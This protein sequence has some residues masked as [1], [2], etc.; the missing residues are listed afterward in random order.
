MAF[1]TEY[2]KLNVFLLMFIIIQLSYKPIILSIY[3]IVHLLNYLHNYFFAKL[4]NYTL[5]NLSKLLSQAYF[6]PFIYFV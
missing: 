1:L 3:Y 5:F 2:K 4:I 6:I